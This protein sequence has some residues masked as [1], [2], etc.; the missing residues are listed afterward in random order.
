ML[1][2]LKSWMVG[3]SATMPMSGDHRESAQCS[4]Q[5]IP[6]VRS[7]DLPRRPPSSWSGQAR[8][9]RGRA[10]ARVDEIGAWY[11]TGQPWDKTG[12]AV[13]QRAN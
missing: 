11:L 8:P 3:P 9:W 6:T 7:N 4:Q 13:K 1:A 5:L 12:R 2:A 10:T